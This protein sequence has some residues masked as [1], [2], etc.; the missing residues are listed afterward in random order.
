MAKKI[1]V[2]QIAQ[3]MGLQPKEVLAYLKDI[4]ITLKS[5]MSSITE[6]EYDR[7]IMY[8]KMKKLQEERR[9]ERGSKIDEKEV[10]KVEVE[11]QEVT[12][13]EVIEE[14][15]IEEVVVGEEEK[16]SGIEEKV[17]GRIEEVPLEEPI[18]ESMVEPVEEKIKEEVREE[19][20]EKI[21]EPKLK[22]RELEKEKVD[23]RIIE[24]KIKEIFFK[25]DRSEEKVQGV[26]D[27]SP[28]FIEPIY[29]PVREKRL[30][31]RR[32]RYR[33]ELDEEALRVEELKSKV[34]FDKGIVRLPETISIPDL[35]IMLEEDESKIEEILLSKGI[36]VKLTRVIPYDIAKMVCEEFGFEVIPDEES[37]IQSLEEEKEEEGLVP[38][39]PVVTV[40][41]HVDHGKTTLLDYIRKTNVAEREAGGITQHIGA[42]KV[43]LPQGEITFID[44][45]GHH[46]FTTMRA[47]GARVTDIV[48]LV[49]AAD[50]GVMPQTVEAI[51]HAKAANVPIIVAINK[52]DKPEAKPD[53]VKQELAQH[54]LIPEEWGGDT[55]MVPISA[56]TG[57]GVDELLEM[58]LLVAEMLDLKANPNKPA[59]GTVLEAKLDPK[60]GP[61][62]TL[63][64]QDGTLREGDAFV[65][66]LCWGKVRAM[67]NERGERLKEAG[68]STPVE[69]LG[70][71]DVPMAGDPF[72]VVEN[73][74]VAREISEER[75]E[76]AKELSVDKGKVTIEEIMKKLME[77]E[78]KE[79]RLIVKADVQGSLEAI[80]EVI[81]RLSTDEIK[82]NI[83]HYGIGAV[84]ETDVMLAKA[85]GAIIIGF[86]VRPDAQARKVIEREKV[87]VRTYKV[88]YDIVE[89][90]KKIMSGMLEP[91]EKEVVLGRAE[92]RQIF[93][94]PKVGNVAGCYVLE[95]KITRNAKIRIIRDGVI[96][97]DGRLSSLKH[98]KEDVREIQ[99]GYECGMAFENFQDIKEGDIVEAYEIQR[100]ERT[101]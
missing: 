85:S 6:D 17:E 34:D 93:K 24:E 94:V 1:R 35:A 86:N 99:A 98:Y 37:V 14:T 12:E 48:I 47:R 68:P 63:L 5:V 31:R 25:R 78:S 56:K 22:E 69:V 97:Y 80:R 84:T 96:V 72:F 19:K 15:L 13:E 45:P 64:V 39:A 62:A 42:Y 101:L 57:Q 73:E 36:P 21:S 90:I 65:A 81:D 26:A 79:L 70:L 76:K 91:E 27:E 33:E 82:V 8:V 20:I 100:I 49:V 43:K 28:Q 74:K 16:E 51:N 2:K 59:R 9:K 4:G 58:V 75:R 53:R 71:S 89:D 50:D 7:L 30:R 38:R 32:K 77:G 61:V 44:T 46:A 54:G 41:G 95:G 23:S 10:L 3:E 52:I 83:V 40:M 18:A 60:K 55:I 67:T 29:Q 11:P 66:G 88:I 92:I 87:E